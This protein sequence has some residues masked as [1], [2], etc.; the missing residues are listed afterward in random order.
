MVGWA[1][2]YEQM[3]RACGHGSKPSHSNLG[4]S[5]ACPF[6]HLD[7]L[8]HH[9]PCQFTINW[10]HCSLIFYSSLVLSACLQTS[11]VHDSALLPPQCF[12][13]TVLFP[14]C[15]GCQFSMHK[16]S[17]QLSELWLFL[18]LL[19]QLESSIHVAR[20]GFNTTVLGWV[21]IKIFLPEPNIKKGIPR[22]SICIHIHIFS[23]PFLTSNSQF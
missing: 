11:L 7:P 20:G 22:R 10:P 12:I 17:K 5:W 18:P 21:F 8:A 16:D 13:S 19:S 4:S 23:K 2:Q 14:A 9:V 15:P 3:D 1:G 6:Y